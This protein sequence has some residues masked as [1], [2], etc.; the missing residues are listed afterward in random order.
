MVVKDVSR[1]GE[2]LLRRGRRTR[3]TVGVFEFHQ[4]GGQKK[5]DRD[6][7]TQDHDSNR[8]PHF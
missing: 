5:Q 8:E 4:Q 3:R 7:R 2:R 6:E 1:S